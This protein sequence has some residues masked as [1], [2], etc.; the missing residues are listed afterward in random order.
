MNFKD[1]FCHIEPLFI[2]PGE[3]LHQKLHT[4]I[5]R[6]ALDK[7]VSERTTIKENFA[8]R[9]GSICPKELKEVYLSYLPLV[10]VI[11]CNELP[12]TMSFFALSLDRANIFKFFFEMISAWLIP[13]RRLNV[14]LTY[15]V[16]FRLPSLGDEVYLLCELMVRVENERQ[17]EQIQN[18]LPA[19]ETEIEMG[20]ASSYYAKKI[21]EIKGFSADEKTAAIQEHIAFLIDRFPKN[22]NQ[23]ALTEMQ[24]ILLICREEFKA[25]REC[26]HL[27]RIIGVH[28]F[29]RQRLLEAFKDAPEKRHLNLKLFRARLNFENE[30]KNVLSVLV[31]VNFF[32]DKEVFDKVHLI[33]AI[34][35]YIPSA[36]PIE[37]SFFANRHGSE[38]VCTLYIEME[39]NNGEAFTGKEIKLLREQLP[40]DLKV[41]IKHFLHPVF[42]PHNEEEVIRN[43]LSLSSQI[44]Y[45]RDIP[46]V[47]ITFDEQ[48]LSHL[49]FTISL[50]RI[51]KPD[52]LSIQEM[53]KQSG[54]FLTYI[55][56]RCQLVGS[57][58]GR[59]KKEATVFRTTLP[60]DQFIR[61][62]HTIDVNKARQIVVS[63]LFKIVGDIRDFNGGMISKQNE[64]L[65]DLKM[66]LKESLKYNEL[67]L[68]NFFYSLTPV[69]MRNVLEIEPLCI[70]FLMLLDSVEE[71]DYEKKFSLKISNNDKFIFIMIKA[72]DRLL[73]EELNKAIGKLQLHSSELAN[74]LVSVYEKIYFGYIYRTDDPDKRQKFSQTIQNVLTSWQPKKMIY[75]RSFNNAD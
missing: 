24:H 27:S 11:N 23:D 12:G 42:M 30:Q 40:N 61:A 47:F 34:Q 53:F 62:D 65:Y 2:G 70:L 17:L 73:K 19:I 41:R 37:N 71:L 25:A 49:F 22:F 57:L 67:L 16:N 3:A 18:H 58:R 66:H 68:E 74:S 32:K 1:L 60:K 6:S 52:S 13:G 35:N 48:T 36:K 63:E 26:R 10:T 28:Y 72:E 15:S 9:E 5:I 38:S 75:S 31:G 56:D 8:D 69:I 7:I 59:H 44:K 46:Q 43:I 64:V 39:K 51:L 14:M 4:D 50:V 45:V 21:L 33:K 20:L 29:F 54:T 55:H